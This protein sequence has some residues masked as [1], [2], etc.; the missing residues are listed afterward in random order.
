VV[1][2]V[3]RDERHEAVG[4]PAVVVRIFLSVLDVHVNRS[5]ADAEVVRLEHRPGR[6]LDARTEA[7]ATLNESNLIVLKLVDGR[8]IGVKQI[9]GAIARRIVCPL[10]PGAR[11]ARGERFG[12]IKVGSTTEL[13]LPDPDRVETLVKVGDRVVGGVT[14]LARIAPA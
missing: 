8:P 6:Y 13:I 11:L 5:P 2:A 3:F 12:M 4:G 9:S 10:E 14:I 7:S 1:S